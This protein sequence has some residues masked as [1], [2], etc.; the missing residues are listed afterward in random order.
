ML[1]LPREP[2]PGEKL[3][4]NW[5]ALIVRYLRSITPRSSPN[6][7][8]SIGANGTT[9]GVSGG[10]IRAVGTTAQLRARFDA[11]A[12]TRT[13]HG[14]ATFGAALTPPRRFL[15]KL[16]T[17]RVY[18]A[19]TAGSATSW[20][21]EEVDPVTGDV[22]TTESDPAY[23]G[24]IAA[25]YNTVT[26]TT[27]TLRRT[28]HTRF[29]SGVVTARL[30]IIETLEDEYTTPRLQADAEADLAAEEW[31]EEFPAEPPDS[32][33]G[34]TSYYVASGICYTSGYALW[35]VGASRAVVPSR[36]ILPTD[37]LTFTV[38]KVRYRVVLPKLLGAGSTFTLEWDEVWR[39][40]L[41]A[42]V[43]DYVIV[44]QVACTGA[45]ADTA[46]DI[47]ETTL[48]RASGEVYLLNARYTA[49]AGAP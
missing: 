16:T 40:T 7:L 34:I 46:S 44:A 30:E 33:D 23:A 49:L 15:T 39:P 14:H 10:A 35:N 6:F 29:T 37:E 18:V 41:D 48:H 4:G 27:P 45:A 8:V 22:T 12:I 3:D 17:Y 26:T 19:G 43:E 13:K 24:S 2:R 20:E 5:G 1:Q 32:G 11:R 9:F 38:Q 21:K 28:T 31:A 42:A 47:V 25:G 36:W